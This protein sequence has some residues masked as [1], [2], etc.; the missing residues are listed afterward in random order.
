MAG[1]WPDPFLD[2]DKLIRRNQLEGFAEPAGPI[3]V[4]VNGTA[5]PQAEM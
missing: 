4:N 2:R 3:N 5:R 1:H